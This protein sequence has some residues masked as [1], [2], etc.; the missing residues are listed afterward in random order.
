M[1]GTPIQAQDQLL[2]PLEFVPLIPTTGSFHHG[3][4]HSATW[5]SL[6]LGNLQECIQQE[7]TR[8]TAESSLHDPGYFR[9]GAP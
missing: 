2:Y 6:I 1:S 9:P 4:I 7:V 8:N 5:V 3:A